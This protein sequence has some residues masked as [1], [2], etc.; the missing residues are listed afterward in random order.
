MTR[1]GI[2]V[3]QSSIAQRMKRS[4]WRLI[5]MIRERN[6]RCEAVGIFFSTSLIGLSVVLMMIAAVG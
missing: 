5:E 1:V 2:A 3:A 4:E 6:E